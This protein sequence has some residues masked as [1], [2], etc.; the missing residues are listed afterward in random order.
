MKRRGRR[1]DSRSFYSHQI[2]TPK[3]NDKSL[4]FLLWV[5]VSKLNYVGSSDRTTDELERIWKEAVLA[6]RDTMPEFA[7]RG[8]GKPRDTSVR[9]SGAADEI[10]TREPRNTSLECYRYHNPLSDTTQREEQDGVTALCFTAP[11]V[12]I[13][14]R[15]VFN[16]FPNFV[17]VKFL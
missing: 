6:N 14:R 17:H 2:S 5:T 1:W 15:N 3:R 10:R 4:Q 7:W 11:K 9:I 16:C 8:W 12:T 13:L